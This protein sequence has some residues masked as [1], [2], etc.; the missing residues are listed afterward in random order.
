MQEFFLGADVSKGYTDFIL[1]DKH[2]EV[3]VRNFQLDDTFKGHSKFHQFLDSFFE[4]HADAVIYAG[5]E[6][7]GGYEDNWIY[8]LRKLQHDYP[9]QVARLNPNNVRN[10]RQAELSGNVTDHISA[11]AIAHHVINV[12]PT[13][14]FNTHSPYASL[15]RTW[16]HLRLLK[17]QKVQLLNQFESLLYIS[18]TQLIR[19]CRSTVPE[20]LLK[21]VVAYPTADHLSR[22]HISKI[23]RIPYITEEK[24]QQLQAEAKASVASATDAMSAELLKDLAT[25]ILSYTQKI[26]KWEKRLVEQCEIAEIDILTTIPNIAEYTAVGLMINMGSVERFAHVKN[27]ASYWGI[28]PAIKESG[29]GQW[30]PGMS[31]EGRSIPRE[32]LFNAVFASLSDEENYIKELYEEYVEEKGKPKMAA[33]GILMHKL[34]RIIYGMLKNGTPYNPNIDRKNRQKSPSENTR[35]TNRKNSKRRLQ[36]FDAQAPVSRREQ[37]KRKGRGETQD[38][39][40]SFAGSSLPSFSET[41]IENRRQN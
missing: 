11:K 17:K 29:D 8:F 3:Q 9:I 16:T 15:K 14:N 41:N 10:T 5:F 28:H 18:H 39:D 13:I 30:K 31:K 7:T 35:N 34:T 27:L 32:L 26:K 12:F 4:E 20:W 6:S 21:L 19:A 36:E 1:L 37:K 2:K 38:A 24:A 23:S 33:I 40:A 22:G 25:T